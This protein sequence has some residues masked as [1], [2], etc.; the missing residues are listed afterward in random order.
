MGNAWIVQSI[1]QNGVSRLWKNEL[2]YYYIGI[3]EYIE[4]YADTVGK[5]L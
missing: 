5:I 1:F 2:V 3:E 4:D